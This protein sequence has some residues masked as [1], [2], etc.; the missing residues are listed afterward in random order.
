MFNVLNCSDYELCYK[1]IKRIIIMVYMN[2]TEVHVFL[3]LH[4]F[5]SFCNYKLVV[6]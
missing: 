2:Y 1:T 5:F 6:N 3:I 4:N